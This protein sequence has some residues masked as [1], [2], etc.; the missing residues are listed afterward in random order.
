MRAA[1]LM[2]ARLAALL[3]API[4]LLVAAAATAVTLRDVE[5]L[6]YSPAPATVLPAAAR[7]ADEEGR[8][9][10]LGALFATRSAI[11]VPGY[12]GCS[13]L[14]GTVVQSLAAALRKA[15]LAPGRDVEVVAISIAPLETPAVAR[16]RMD[17]L[18]GPGRHPGWHFL[19]ADEP[20]IAALSASLGYRAAYDTASGA[21]A[22]PT[23]I[24]VVDRGGAVRRVL[25]GVAFDPAELRDALAPSTEPARAP[26]AAPRRW[27]LCFHDAIAAGR[28]DERVRRG[29]QLGG[30]GALA[31]LG[32]VVL[33]AAR[34]RRNREGRP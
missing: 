29:L 24:T 2:P 17:A 7:F 15:R 5:A 23:G 8:S 20:T 6:A 10:T 21:Y 25:P 13:S 4:A 27:L 12:Y 18:L 9:V 11:V 31:G 14:C 30:L 34:T 22:H 32:L 28:Y 33:V 16:A 1:A 3:L 19:T 26:A